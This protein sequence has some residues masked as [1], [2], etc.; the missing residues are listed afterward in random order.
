MQE[1][2]P[3][4]TLVVATVALFVGLRTIRQRDLADRREQWWKRFAWAAEL[5]L[6]DEG[7]RR[8]LGLRS[9]DLLAVSRLGGDEELELL[10]SAVSVELERRPEVLDDGWTGY[11][12]EGRRPEGEQP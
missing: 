5:T 6:S 8:D 7:H 9:L 4:A 3:I 11:D 12:D 1:L 2:A 10:D